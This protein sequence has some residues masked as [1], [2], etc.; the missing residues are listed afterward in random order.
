MLVPFK[1]AGFDLFLSP[2]VPAIHS[3]VS[4]YKF[5]IDRRPDLWY[6]CVCSLGETSS[7]PSVTPA[8]TL[9][10]SIS[11]SLLPLFF[12]LTYFVFNTLQPL[13]PNA[14]FA[15]RTGLREHGGLHPSSQE[16]RLV[17][18]RCL[19]VNSLHPFSSFAFRVPLSEFRVSH[20]EFRPSL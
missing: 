10:P 15:S 20:F 7:T 9:D 8:L 2:K 19:P 5:T 13:S 1:R 14:P 18:F 4:T 11:C 17:L 12:P 6:G 3:P 16:S